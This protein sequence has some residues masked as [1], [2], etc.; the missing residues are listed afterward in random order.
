LKLDSGDYIISVKP[1]P[2]PKPLPKL[3]KLG[4]GERLAAA[5]LG[6]ALALAIALS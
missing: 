1:A 2:P 3:S 5:V 4:P 6:F